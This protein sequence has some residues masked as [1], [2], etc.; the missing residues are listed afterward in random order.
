[1]H[2]YRY[3]CICVYVYMCVCMYIYIYIHIIVTCLMHA[4]FKRGN[5][6][7]EFIF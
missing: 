2:V 3:V 5:S 7:S 6:C 1:M 4:F